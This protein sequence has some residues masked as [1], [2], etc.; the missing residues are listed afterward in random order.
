M[1]GV[2]APLGIRHLRLKFDQQA[3]AKPRTH[4]KKRA[5]LSIGAL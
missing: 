4:K 3:V 5:D 1:C 2:V